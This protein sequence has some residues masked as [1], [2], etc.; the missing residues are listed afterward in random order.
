MRVQYEIRIENIKTSN[1]SALRETNLTIETNNT[2][3]LNKRTTNKV[4]V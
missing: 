1:D 3:S 2:C 4:Y